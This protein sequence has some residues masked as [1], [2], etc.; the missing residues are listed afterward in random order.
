MCDAFMTRGTIGRRVV[1][2]YQFNTKQWNENELYTR[3]LCYV[4]VVL[5][6]RIVH[7]K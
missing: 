6:G 4:R 2:R 7:D 3:A 1:D 5:L